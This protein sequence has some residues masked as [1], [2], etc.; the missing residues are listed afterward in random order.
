MV[1]GGAEVCKSCNGAKVCK[2][3]QS[4]AEVL[5]GCRGSAVM[6]MKCR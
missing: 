2:G 4:C 1:N 3:V 6:V 5:S